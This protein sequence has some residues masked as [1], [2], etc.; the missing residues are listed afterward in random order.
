[1]SRTARGKRDGTGPYSGSAQRR[2]TGGRG[3]RQ[4]AGQRCPKR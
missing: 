1:M 4:L 3:K 2:A